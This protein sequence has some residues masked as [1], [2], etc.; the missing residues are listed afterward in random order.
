MNGKDTENVFAL[1]PQ[2]KSFLPA[3]SV[4]CIFK[5]LI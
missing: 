2:I 5:N 3:E 4:F 1:I